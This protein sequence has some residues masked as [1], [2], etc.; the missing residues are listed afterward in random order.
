MIGLEFNC[1]DRAGGVACPCTLM[2]IQFS[3][4]TCRTF[5]VSA[6]KLGWLY[7]VFQPWQLA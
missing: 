6:I 5:S 1:A 7:S 3:R 2:S 4:V